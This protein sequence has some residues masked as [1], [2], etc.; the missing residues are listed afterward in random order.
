MKKI[1]LSLGLLMTFGLTSYA[2]T[3]EFNVAKFVADDTGYQSENGS[4]I[5]SFDSD[6]F[7]LICE[8]G[9]MSLKWWEL[10]MSD[11]RAY[12]G[13]I[14]TIT[15][16][17]G[18][19]LGIESIAFN[20][21]NPVG[22]LNAEPFEIKYSTLKHEDMEASA[23]EIAISGTQMIW[24][25]P[26][27]EQATEVVITCP[28]AGNAYITSFILYFDELQQPSQN[29]EAP[30]IQGDLEF[31]ESTEVSIVGE[32]GTSIYY[33]LD[34]TVPTTS[35]TLYTAPF[36]ITAST[37]V[38]AIAEKD[39]VTSSVSTAEFVKKENDPGPVVGDIPQTVSL[40]PVPGSVK[41]NAFDN[42]LSI[43]FDDVAI[44]VGE[45]KTICYVTGPTGKEFSK[46]LTVTSMATNYGV[47]EF[48]PSM[49]DMVGEYTFEIY[50]EETIFQN[51]QGFNQ[52]FGNFRVKYT[53][54]E[55]GE[56]P[57]KEPE[58]VPSYITVTPTPP[59]AAGF[60]GTVTMTVDC[61]AVFGADGKEAVTMTK[62][63]G[64]EKKLALHWDEAEL[65]SVTFT[66]PEEDRALTGE[67]KFVVDFASSFI[68]VYIN[69]AGVEKEVPVFKFVYNLDPAGVNT[70]SAAERCFDIYGIDGRLVRRAATGFEGIDPGVYVAGGKKV[71]VK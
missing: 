14:L 34:G 45:E 19:K 57:V 16:K 4:Y 30:R 38:R 8:Q 20:Y 46:E 33:T 35:S 54:T 31:Y 27:G 24:T 41:A 29:V 52:N 5:D 63:D 58:D 49:F 39:G 7:D 67:Y 62:P 18:R 69:S 59:Q 22:G 42:G 44:I 36:T 25:L 40:S 13:N 1:L 26:Q 70:V 17:D 3:E 28:I 71:L 48:L 60:D 47:F 32:E 64:T 61:Y 10:R 65:N 11:M 56:D 66:V 37:T 53:I 55:L 50:T 9:P 43:S 23:S 6:Y 2:E 21:K 68:K 51:A 15:P 12:P